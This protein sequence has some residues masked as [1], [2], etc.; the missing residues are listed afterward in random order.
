MRQPKRSII[1]E[2]VEAARRPGEEDQQWQ[3]HKVPSTV[4]NDCLLA[5][6]LSVAFTWSL[7][8]R[9]I[10]SR[11][12]QKRQ[13]FCTSQLDVINVL[14]EAVRVW[15]KEWWSFTETRKEGEETMKSKEKVDVFEAKY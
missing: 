11:Q 6:H 7:E 2:N 8:K 14:I 15:Q 13:P 4:A 5:C 3:A 1:M 10:K 9:Q 12:T